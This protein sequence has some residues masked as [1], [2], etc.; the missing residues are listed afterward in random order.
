MLRG[1]IRKSE[2]DTKIKRNRDKI[3]IER[4]KRETKHGSI[5][6]LLKKQ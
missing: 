6:N 1:L 2:R 3:E 4:I 5:P